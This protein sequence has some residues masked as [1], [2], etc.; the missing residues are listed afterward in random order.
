M[1]RNLPQKTVDT[2]IDMQ[3]AVRIEGT[4]INYKLV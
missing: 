2:K 1:K 3:D 4:V